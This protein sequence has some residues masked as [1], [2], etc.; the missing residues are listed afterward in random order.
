[1]IVESI[2]S[3][4]RYCKYNRYNTPAGLQR[5]VWGNKFST[6]NFPSSA[7]DTDESECST[8]SADDA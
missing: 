3:D 4:I 5:T 6:E 8:T 7:Q 1:M 2:A